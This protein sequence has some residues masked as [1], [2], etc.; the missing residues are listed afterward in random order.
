MRELRTL[1]QAAKLRYRGLYFGDM[2]QNL[3]GANYALGHA[4]VLDFLDA[5]VLLQVEEFISADDE[6]MADIL[7]SR[8]THRQ[9]EELCCPSFGAWSPYPRCYSPMDLLCWMPGTFLMVCW[10]SAIQW[11]TPDADSI[12]AQAFNAA[13][14]K[15]LAGKTDELTASGAS[16]GGGW[17]CAP[18]FKAPQAFRG[19]CQV[20]AAKCHPPDFKCRQEALQ[21]GSSGLGPRASPDVTVDLGDDLIFED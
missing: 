2:T 11:A 16:A 21:R 9:L 14:V 20:Q 7:P 13:V 1:K 12:H 19:A 15:V 5:E 4:L 3:T 17:L 10:R 6:E 8:T 18:D